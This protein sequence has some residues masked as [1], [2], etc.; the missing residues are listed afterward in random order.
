MGD[1]IPCFVNAHQFRLLS[2]NKHVHA[3]GLIC[4]CLLRNNPIYTSNWQAEQPQ[5]T[6]CWIYGTALTCILMADTNVC[7]DAQPASL[8]QDALESDME[9]SRLYCVR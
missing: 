4:L 9:P 5:P 3:P 2:T 7:V 8:A 1:A 6:R